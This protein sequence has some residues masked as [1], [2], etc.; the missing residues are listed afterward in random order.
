MQTPHVTRAAFVALMLMAAIFSLSCTRENKEAPTT[1]QAAP[2]EASIDWCA[3]HRVPESECTQCNPALVAAFKAKPDWCVEHGVPESHCYQCNNGLSFPQEAAYL[4]RAGSAVETQPATAAVDWCAEHRVPESECT[5]CKPALVAVFKA[6]PDWC[7]SHGVPESHCYQCN[8]DLSFPQEAAWLKQQ[9]EE[10]RRASQKPSTSLFRSNKPDCAT[11]D[12]LVQF[13][14]LE[15][16]ARA[17]ILSEVVGAGPSGETL[18][19]PAEVSFDAGSASALITRV[20]GNLSRWVVKP[21]ERVQAGQVV[22]WLESADAAAVIAAFQR[23]ESALELARTT[24][25]R[26]QALSR[27]ALIGLGELQE[28]EAA[29][30]QA[31][32]DEQSAATALRLIGQSA[33]EI[34]SPARGGQDGLIPIKAPTS[35]VLVEQRATL[36]ASLEAGAPLGTIAE[37]GRLW[38]EARVRERDLPRIALGQRAEIVSEGLVRGVGAVSWVADL[39]DPETRMGLVR[40]E[41]KQEGGALRLHQFVQARIAI[42]P[43]AEAIMIPVDAV[44]WE[45]CCNVVFVEEA[46]DRFRP[47]K[48]SIQYAAD[49]RCAVSGLKAGEHIVTQGSYLLKTEIMKSSIGA[50][51]CGV[52]A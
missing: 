5:T 7:A 12:A 18:L 48:V 38:I 25:E 47:R 28:A 6:K 2:G 17:G 44:Q 52:G 40:L 8:T 35:G 34:A 27:D 32:A 10:K 37:T 16:A 33:A 19:V 11:N 13:S 46:A 4:A 51:C 50:G 42:A 20:Q 9:D 31:Q 23:A 41:A 1:E 49:G 45:G 36:G 30:Q 3:E 43:L 39:I 24:R 15:T 22:A 26:K 29:W 21:G 14:S